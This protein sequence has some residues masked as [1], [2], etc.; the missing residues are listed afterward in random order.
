M[1]RISAVALARP[2]IISVASPARVA[3]ASSRSRARFIEVPICPAA[4]ETWRDAVTSAAEFALAVAVASRMPSTRSWMMLERVLG[5]GGE[6]FGLAE[7][8]GEAAHRRDDILF[9]D[10]H[11]FAI[12]VSVA[13]TAG[14]GP[15]AGGAAPAGAG[16]S[17]S[18]RLRPLSQRRT[19]RCITSPSPF[20]PCF[21]MVDIV[22]KGSPSCRGRPLCAGEHGP[23]RPG[24]LAS[25]QHGS[26]C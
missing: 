10:G 12:D 5:F 23:L 1:P 7:I 8:V 19:A 4:S 3:A 6:M 14:A 17:A 22:K 25:K 2:V 26:Q 16:S 24:G 15:A 11:G 18:V 21:V 13:A 9:E 20:K